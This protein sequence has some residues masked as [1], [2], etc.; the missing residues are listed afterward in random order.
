MRTNAECFVSPQ[1]SN[2]P[3]GGNIYMVENAQT[4]T[5]RLEPMADHTTQSATP[6][7][8]QMKTD[9]GWKCH[10]CISNCQRINLLTQSA[11]LPWDLY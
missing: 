5:E 6:K 8:G 11:L 4:A 3:L 2:T 7:S 1:F 10:K 9:A